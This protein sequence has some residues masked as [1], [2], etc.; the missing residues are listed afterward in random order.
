MSRRSH[1][2]KYVDSHSYRNRESYKSSTDKSVGSPYKSLG[3]ILPLKI[4]LGVIHL[5]LQSLGGIIYQLIWTINV[6]SVIEKNIRCVNVS[7]L[8][9]MFVMISAYISGLS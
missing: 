6:F 7:M 8:N 5:D 4:I 9:V 3:V 2:D 1:D